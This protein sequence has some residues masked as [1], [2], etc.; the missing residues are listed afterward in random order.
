L[1]VN[2]T[3]IGALQTDRHPG[4]AAQVVQNAEY[5]NSVAKHSKSIPLIDCIA[6]GVDRKQRNFGSMRKEVEA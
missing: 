6:V 5:G 3:R 4:G 1:Q 2:G